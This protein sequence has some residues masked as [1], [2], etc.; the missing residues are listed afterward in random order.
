MKKNPTIYIIMAAAGHGKD[1]VKELIESELDKRS[2]EIKFAEKAKIIIANSLKS[3]FIKPEMKVEEKIDI[4]ND[5]KDNKMSTKVLGEENMRKMLQIILG[6]VIRTVNPDLHA[7]FALKK[8]EENLEKGNEN[9]FICTD[10]RYINEQKFLYPINL[11]QTKEEKIDYIR[12]TIHENKT[13]SSDNEIL[14]LFDKLT[15]KHVKDG[16]DE[17]MLNK[18]KMKFVNEDNKLKNTKNPV[19]DYYEFYKSIDF[20]KIKEMSEKEGFENGLINIFRPLIEKNKE[21]ECLST[22]E[23]KEKIKEFNNISIKEVSEVENNYNEF[24]ID[25]NYDNIVKY[26]FLR[27]NPNHTSERELD[28]RKP[29]A[30]I[31]YPESH[32]DSIKN[33]ISNFFEKNEKNKEKKIKI[34]L[35]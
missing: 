9:L 4:L 2:I 22:N 7:L 33:K 23:L 31:N 17:L 5:L 16:S 25:F 19:F 29:K 30:L 27:A 12:W 15:K 3:K 32:P 6:D 26:G 18:I 10:N 20:N 8:I 14:E 1:Y 21:Y 34:K 28:G 11:L 13:K 35:N 24:N